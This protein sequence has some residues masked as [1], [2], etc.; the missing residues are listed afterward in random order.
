M[1][2]YLV[3]LALGKWK[4]NPQGNIRKQ[5]LKWRRLTMPSV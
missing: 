2:R 5:V 1:T 4:S 3:S